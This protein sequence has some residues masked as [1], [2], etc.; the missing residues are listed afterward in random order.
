MN[1]KETTMR[2]THLSK[3]KPKMKTTRIGT[4]YL[5]ALALLVTAGGSAARAAEE[6]A[7]DAAGAERMRRYNVVWTSPSKDATGVMPLGNGDIAAGVYAIEGGDL[8]LLLAKNDAFNYA[9]EIYK[10]GRVRV[11]LDPN[12]F[13]PGKPFRQTLDLPTGSIR[14][15]AGGV[16]LH[17]WADANRPV[18]HVEI[19]APEEITVTARPELWERLDGTQNVCLPRGGNILWYFAVGDRSVYPDDLKFYEVEHMASQFPDPYRFNTF[20]NLLESPALTPGDGTLSGK[21]KDFDVRIHACTM[22]TPKVETWIET[23]EGQAAR[24]ID[25]E[26]DWR[27]HCA[28]WASFWDRSWIVASDN[29][30]PPE[31]REKLSGEPSASG[32]REEEDGAALVAQS[33][34][35]F[36]FLMACQSRGR[37]QAKFNGGLFTQRLRASTNRGRKGA[38]QQPDG[39]WITHED[40]RLWGRRFTYQ[41]Q[42]LLYWPLLAGGDFDLMQPFFHYYS[43]LLEM[44]AAITK[45]W[46]GH[47]G[48]YYRENIEPTGGERDCGK[49]G[50]PP[51]TKPGESYVGWY[52]DYYFTAGLE[53]L[54][55]MSEYAK[56][57]G[58]EAFRDRVLVPFAREVLLFFDLHYPRDA[59]GKLRLEPAQVLETWWIAV[60]PAPDVA[61]LRFALDELLLMKAGTPEDQTVWQRFLGE[62]P[63]VSMQEIDGRQAIAPAEKWE[64]KHNAEN[65]ELYPV[66]PFRCFGLGLGSGDIVA[67]TMEHRSCKDAFGSRCWTQDQIHWAYAG[68]AA[69]ARDGLIRR[70][71]AASR[72][73]RFPLYGR[74]GPDSCPDFDHFGSGATA[75]QRMLVQEAG[76]KIL[77][78]P[79]WPADWDADFKLHLAGEAVLSGTVKDGKLLAW[80][81]QPAAR[82]D[83][84]VVGQP[85]DVPPASCVPPNAHPLRAGSDQQGQN[86]FRGKIG[87]VTMFRGRLALPAIRDLAA[88]DRSRPIES[89]QVAGCWL[90]P[91][92]GDPLP[93]EAED[94]AGPVSFEAWIQ[95]GEN[96]SG[97][98][99]D[100]LT[101]GVNDGFLLDAWPKLSLRLIVGGQQ[102]RDFPEVLKPG[103]WQ[104]VAVVIDRGLPR[105]YLDGQPPTGG[106]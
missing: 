73:C 58:D 53:T 75:L 57:T 72:K 84:V 60:N 16:T 49:D 50:R 46:F 97:R 23:I 93:T 98:V 6:N 95:P 20:G 30:L 48:A 24:P 36:R 39:T 33:Y 19:T 11:S 10:T 7:V 42:R 63:E 59:S 15:E 3:R 100:K 94:F 61:G 66:F 32:I 83:D 4:K 43:N 35:V 12:P 99:L 101:A 77:L 55:M 27:A 14:I 13:L 56:Y 9:G 96:E 88:G 54:V 41:N 22:Q 28:W 52:H 82:R 31:A 78:L 70:F 34:N 8:Y 25:A 45:A 71:R 102:Q 69:E 47:G 76:D 5:L 87:R 81:I 38:T 74:E 89:E 64:K 86:R 2:M 105:V 104:H 80:D 85:Q 21:G 29:T 67:W 62:I 17:V 92:P 106:R 18:Y 91:T 1:R 68:R 44:R 90:N 40:D 37:I 103:V 79:A 51:K 26:Q 65:G